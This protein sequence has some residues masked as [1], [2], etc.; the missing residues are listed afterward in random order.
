MDTTLQNDRPDVFTRSWRSGRVAAAVIPQFTVGPAK[1]RL[2]AAA[3]EARL[4]PGVVS[5]TDID[6]PIQ[7]QLVPTAFR[8]IREVRLQEFA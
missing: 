1:L 2:E 8:G 7:E 6:A 3:T 5:P 4:D